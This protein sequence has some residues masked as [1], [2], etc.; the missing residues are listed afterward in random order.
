VDRDSTSAPDLATVVLQ[1]FAIAGAG[2]GGTAALYALASFPDLSGEVI[3]VEPGRLKES[4]LGRYLMS[5]YDQ[6]HGAMHKLE[7]VKRFLA[8]HSP[9]IRIQGEPRFWN[10]VAR[11]WKTVLATVDTPEARW[12]VQRSGPQV[13]LDAGVIGTLYAVLRVVPGGWCLECK[14]PPDPA[15]TWKRRA[16][17]WGM[18]V[19][20]RKSSADSRHALRSREPI[21]NV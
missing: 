3:L 16:R 17:R 7:S 1:D 5:T 20:S 14:H 6:V 21:S 10:E 13:I 15:V 11:D 9:R 2:A 18:P 8:I 19:A 4:S 12:D